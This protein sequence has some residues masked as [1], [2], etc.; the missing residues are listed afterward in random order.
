MKEHFVIKSDFDQLP[1]DVLITS[2]SHP[3]GIVQFSHG[4]CEH[5]ER[6]I[7]FMEFLNQHGYV[8]CIH[9]HRGHGHS[10]YSNEDLGYF[11]QDGHMG[12]VEDVHQLTL[13]MKKR[14]PLLPIYLVI[15]WGLWL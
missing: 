7:D 13:L 8:C 2:P 4:M 10:V 9:D 12:I 1:L 3:K 14:Y 15:V 6:Y 11:Y 5:K